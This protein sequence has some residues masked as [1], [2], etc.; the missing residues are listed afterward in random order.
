[1]EQQI[2][3][4]L[5]HKVKEAS[6]CELELI[7][8]LLALYYNRINMRIGKVRINTESKMNKDE[9]NRADYL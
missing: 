1:M 8:N 5:Q 7:Q 9:I 3:N 6:G 2:I 4:L